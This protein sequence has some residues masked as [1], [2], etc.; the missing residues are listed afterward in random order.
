LIIDK[1]W[2]VEKPPL[3][4]LDFYGPKMF[5]D[6]FWLLPIEA[7]WNR[8]PSILPDSAFEHLYQEKTVFMGGISLEGQQDAAGATRSVPMQPNL[9]DKRQ[10]LQCKLLH[11]ER[12]YRP[13]GRRFPMA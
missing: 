10:L 4:I 9:N 12:H 13:Y 5:D 1:A 6:P 7:V 2:G 11:K 8:L 3:A